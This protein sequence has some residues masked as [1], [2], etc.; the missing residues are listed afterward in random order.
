MNMDKE[1][2]PRYVI[3]ID[4]GTASGRAVL[5]DVRD[6][7]ELAWHVTPYP[8]GVMEEELISCGIRLGPEWA[9]QH[10]GDYV[11]VLRRSVPEVL[12]AAGVSSGQVIGIGVDFTSCTMLPVDEAGT[13]LFL[14]EAYRREPHAYVKLWKH[15]AAQGEADLINAVA[16]ERGEAFLSRY[17]GKISSEWM[18]PKGL[19]VLR[20]APE[21]YAA[22]D[23]FV[24]AADWI[25]FWMTGEMKRS[26]G[27]A[28]YKALWHSEE[29]YP[30]AEFYRALDPR[31]ERFAE[32]KL[33]GEIAPL[34]R[35]AGRLTAA[36]AAVMGLHPGIPVA[37]GMIDAHAAVPGVGATK[38]GQMVLSMGTSLCHLLLS[39]KELVVE[40]I[41]GM[42]RDGIIPGL[43]AYEAGQAAVGDLFGWYVQQGVPAYV[44][45]AADN[46]GVTVHKWLER[47]AS[48]LRPGEHGLMALDWWNGNR[49]VLV[50]AHLSGLIM[51]LTL[52]TKPEEIYRALL[53]ATAFGTRKVIDAFET[54]GV[55]VREL[56]ACGGLPGK[57]RLLMQIFADVTGREIKIAASAQTPALGAAML[58]AVAAGSHCGGYDRI[59][60]AAER[61]ARVQTETYRPNPAYRAVYDQLYR[62]Y[63][64]LHDL[65]GRGGSEAMARLKRLQREA[66]AAGG[67]RDPEMRGQGDGRAQ[68]NERR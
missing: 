65:F 3:G 52:H 26:S 43:Y 46:E 32:T 4:F 30:S 59:E 48:R 56:F 36:A 9:L 17:G 54:A 8:H 10:P 40:G 19:Q 12:G 11:E 24:E 49:S 35:A 22:A 53:E 63:T 55:K 66:A 21:V 50:N 16:A 2:E 58:G 41:C 23:R 15:H 29:G 6:G 1:T 51:G 64:E 42:V 61:M 62:E 47:R 27:C 34:G 14:K 31:F 38:P 18:V 45:R 57:N 67:Q 28:G 20:E 44:E 13:P 39:D 60:E 25:V 5:V 7:C 37:P 33:R 68:G